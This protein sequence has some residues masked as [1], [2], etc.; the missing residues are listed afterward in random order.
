MAR[1]I[2]IAI[3]LLVGGAAMADAPEARKHF[4][5]GMKAYNL[6]DFKGALHEFQSA[7]VELPDPAFLYNIAQSQRQLGQYEAASKS[8]HMYLANQPSAPNRDQV[9]KFIEQMDKAAAAARPPQAAPALAPPPAA[10]AVVAAPAATPAPQPERKWYASPLGWGLVGGGVVLVG[11]SGGL[12]GIAMSERD[13]ALS[14]TSQPDFDSHHNRSITFQQ[15]GWPLLAV[16]GAAV[17]GG[18]VVLAL[19][20]RS[21]HR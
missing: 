8:Y 4:D 14:A 9:L 19:R 7:Y 11:V 17:V 13:K 2:L 12:L 16:G 10:P 5:R 6:L 15:A 3:T 18:G 21:A 1:A 20:A